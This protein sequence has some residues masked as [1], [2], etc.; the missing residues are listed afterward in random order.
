M[1]SIYLHKNSNNRKKSKKTLI[2]FIY[3]QPNLGHFLLD[4][5]IFDYDYLNLI[6]IL[7]K[8]L[9]NLYLCW[10]QG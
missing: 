5:S 8:I 9:I 3:P 7:H 4:Q 10:Q 6:D 2:K 1:L